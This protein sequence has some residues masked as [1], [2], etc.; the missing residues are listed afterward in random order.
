MKALLSAERSVASWV[1]EMVEPRV[2]GTADLLVAKTVGEWVW[3][4]VVLKAVSSVDLLVVEMVEQTAD[5][6][7]DLWAAEMAAE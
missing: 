6:K 4:W 3:K 5:S 7:A 1:V 2:A